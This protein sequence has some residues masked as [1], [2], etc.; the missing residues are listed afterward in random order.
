VSG[1]SCFFIG[2]R[3]APDDLL[4]ILQETVNRHIEEYGVTEF[5]VGNYGG[6]D[7]LAAKAVITA[8]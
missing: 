8:K 7:Y 2:H 3:D 5:I 6:F 1:K 4:P